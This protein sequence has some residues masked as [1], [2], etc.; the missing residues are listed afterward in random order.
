MEKRAARARRTPDLKQSARHRPTPIAARHPPTEPLRSSTDRP[1]KT[2][3]SRATEKRTASRPPPP[4]LVRSQQSRSDL[5][6]SPTGQPQQS[7][8]S[9]AMEKRTTERQAARAPRQ[10][11]GQKRSARRRPPPI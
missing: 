7:T 5:W 6:R 9:R 11:L 4:S 1:Q 3:R 10:V 8:W 2:S